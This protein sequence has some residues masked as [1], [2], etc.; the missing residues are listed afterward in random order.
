MSRQMSILRQIWSF[1]K[2]S[3]FWWIMFNLIWEASNQ[4]I[5]NF[6]NLDFRDFE[7]ISFYKKWRNWPRLF[8]KLTSIF[9][10]KFKSYRMCN[11]KILFDVFYL[12]HSLLNTGIYPPFC[13][14]KISITI[15]SFNEL[16]I[17]EDPDTQQ[18]PV[19]MV[20]NYGGKIYWWYRTFQNN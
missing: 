19:F 3:W 4:K 13:N 15:K 10:C 7:I 16:N 9:L 8:S 11:I 20:I 12:M 14:I 1:S 18:T 6:I 17:V 5:L 2:S